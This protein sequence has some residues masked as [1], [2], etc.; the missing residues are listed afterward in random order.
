LTGESGNEAIHFSA[1]RCAVESK[2]VR[3]DRR[4]IKDSR[5]HKR[6]KLAGCSGFEFHVANGSVSDAKK[7]ECGSCAFSEHPDSGA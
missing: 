6:D 1:P 2:Q 5:F 3:P 7:V 4:R